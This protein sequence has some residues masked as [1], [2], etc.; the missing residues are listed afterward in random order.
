MLIEEIKNL[1]AN[2][3]VVGIFAASNCLL[4][5]F[6]KKDSYFLSCDLTDRSGTIPAIMW[7][8]AVKVKTW[9]KNKTVVEVEGTVSIYKNQPRISIEK[10]SK[11]DNYDVDILMPSLDAD[12]IKTYHTLL[13]NE[14]ENVGNYD[15]VWRDILSYKKF[16]QCPGGVGNVHHNYLGGL[17]EHSYEMVEMAKKV[18]EIYP[19]LDRNLLMTGALVH[20]IGKLESYNWDVV[21]EM[22]DKGRLF[23]HTVLGFQYISEIN[24][25]TLCN[26]ADINK[27]KHMILSHHGDKGLVKPMFAEAAVLA[28]I[29]SNSASVNYITNFVKENSQEDSNWTLWSNLTQTF[30]FHNNQKQF[31]IPV[32]EKKFVQT[33]DN[34]NKPC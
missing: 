23:G 21:I 13:H 1:P 16:S 33:K 7:E 2:T 11:I 22:S 27:L 30:Y 31:D 6:T 25:K 4:K 12:Q 29:D 9:L 3:P 14:I 26:G 34:I 24:T 17:I 19:Q 10:I 8:N 28:S 32:E 15:Y 20:D 18:C 5:A